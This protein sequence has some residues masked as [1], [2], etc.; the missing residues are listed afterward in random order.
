MN[1]VN[2]KGESEILSIASALCLQRHSHS[3]SDKYK[4]YLHQRSKFKHVGNIF[5]SGFDL[6]R[7]KFYAINSSDHVRFETR[8][9]D[10]NLSVDCWLSYESHIEVGSKAK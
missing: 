9:H 3:I 5:L 6:L 1:F 7:L 4:R 8:C 10:M 2:R